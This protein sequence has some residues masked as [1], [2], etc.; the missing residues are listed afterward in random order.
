MCLRCL[1]AKVAYYGHCK[2]NDYHLALGL[3][4]Q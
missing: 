3:K 2:H 1:G 4:A